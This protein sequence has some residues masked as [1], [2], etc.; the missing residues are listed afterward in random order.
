YNK[1]DHEPLK[2]TSITDGNKIS[3]NIN[4]KI[5]LNDTVYSENNSVQNGAYPM[6]KTKIPLMV[7]SNYTHGTFYP[8][9]E[10][11][12]IAPPEKLIEFARFYN[13][14]LEEIS[15][16]ELWDYYY[17]DKD[18]FFSINTQTTKM[19]YSNAWVLHNGLGLLGFDQIESKNLDTGK[20]TVTS[21]KFN[22]SHG[23]A[24]NITQKTYLDATLQTTT[25]KDINLE[26]FASSAYNEKSYLTYPLKTVTTNHVFN[27]VNTKTNHYTS[28]DFAHGKPS[29]QTE[30]FTDGYSQ[31]KLYNYESFGDKGFYRLADVVDIKRKSGEPDYKTKFINTYSDDDSSPHPTVLKSKKQVFYKKDGNESDL[32]L[33]TDYSYDKYGNTNI[34]KTK[35][36]SVYSDGTEIN[37]VKTIGYLYKNGLHLTKKITPQGIVESEYNKYGLKISETD[38]YGLKTKFEYNGLFRLSKETGPDGIVKSYL[39]EK[40][41]NGYNYFSK[42]STSGKSDVYKYFLNDGKEVQQKTFDMNDRAIITTKYYNDKDELIEETMPHF[43]GDEEVVTVYKTY[44]RDGRLS[45]THKGLTAESQLSLVE[46]EYFKRTTTVKRQGEDYTSHDLDGVGKQISTTDPGGTIRYTTNALGETRLINAPGNTIEI[47]FDEFGFKKKRIDKSAGTISFVYNPT[48]KILEQTDQHGYLTRYFYDSKG[49]LSR[50]EII[51]NESTT[52]TID[53][54]Y[55]SKF[56]KSISKVTMSNGT[57]TEFYYNDLGRLIR[58]KE[59]VDNENFEWT[60]AYDS[61]GRVLRERFPSGFTIRNVYKSNGFLY[62]IKNASNNAL[63]WQANDANALGKLT[64]YQNGNGEIT[65]EE[66]DVYGML[67]RKK[68]GNIMDLGY[69]FDLDKGNLNNRTDNLRGLTERFTYDDFDRL[70]SWRVNSIKTYYST[71]NSNNAIK[72]KTDAGQ[73]FTY[74]GNAPHKLYSVEGG[75][76]SDIFHEDQEVTYNIF[77]KTATILQDNGNK[78][79]ALIY[80]YTE[81]RV[82]SEFSLSGEL[83]LTKY[84][85]GNYEV[86]IAND[87]SGNKRQIHHLQG[88]IYVKNTAGAN[89]DT[90]YYVHT[91]YLGSILAITNNKNS[92][93][94]FNNFDPWGRMRDP[95][96]WEYKDELH[97]AIF[98]RGFTGHQHLAHFQLIN[99]NGRMYDP[100]LGMFLSPDNYLQNANSTLNYNGFL[101]AYGNPFKFTDPEGEFVITA[102]VVFGAIIG[103]YTGY[104]VAE[105]KGYDFGDWQTYAFIVGGAVVGGY[106]GHVGGAVFANIAQNVGGTAG[107]IWAGAC[108][109]ALT[110]AMNSGVS[111]IAMGEN[112]EGVAKA[113]LIGGASGA[114]SGAITAGFGQNKYLGY[115]AATNIRDNLD[116]LTGED[117]LRL[118]LGPVSYDFDGDEFNSILNVKDNS[119]NETIEYLY[120]TMAMISALDGLTTSRKTISRKCLFSNKR[121]PPGA[122]YKIREE[123]LY[124]F[125]FIL[126]ASRRFSRFSRCQKQ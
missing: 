96:T 37:E 32:T 85:F 106:S 26:V 109:G 16:D 83:T 1:N 11:Y 44:Y 71:Y 72:S 112:L 102:A 68:V 92:Q 12:Y 99:M 53:Y 98:D 5:T 59:V 89:N 48:G 94:E 28:N 81:Q 22:T 51:E 75:V 64:N 10:E 63:I 82:K 65:T 29:R 24:K 125:Y 39:T 78:E 119:F 17:Y 114:F 21:Y 121:R 36:K 107:T 49:R 45:S 117:E 7:V 61:Y 66:Y 38:F 47:E 104:K 57:S 50:K 73:T 120:G 77:D 2:L 86:E 42:V 56:S 33:N 30:S 15:Q 23:F 43:E 52:H 27:T 124:H 8:M 34:T 97:L 62:Q 67:E 95:E 55:H 69:S 84:Y 79:L 126:A 91:N 80:N 46:Y 40:E 113:I 110:G 3:T 76:E 88:A 6:V 87:G 108:S 14:E 90:M 122:Y 35:Y 60:Y 19:H 13:D 18:L 70:R 118:T 111:A 58:R 31:E 25:S 93:K 116:V 103:A 4:Y 101:Y 100:V 123:V 105:A 9:E 54:S 115:L 41:Q 74:L 20:K